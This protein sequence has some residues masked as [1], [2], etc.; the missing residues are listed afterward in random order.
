MQKLIRWTCSTNAKDIGMLYIVFGLFSALVG[1]S[2]SL[3]IR[4]ELSGPGSQFIDSDKYGQI[5]N[6]LI[7][8]HGLVMIFMFLMPTLIGGFGNYLLPLMIG[9]RRYGIS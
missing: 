1:T 8:S 4:L 6:V 2:L 3:L 9:G 7:T 5:Y